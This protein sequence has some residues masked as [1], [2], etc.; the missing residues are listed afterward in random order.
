[1]SQ[2]NDRQKEIT[3]GRKKERKENEKDIILYSVALFW[4]SGFW[5]TGLWPCLLGQTWANLIR[6]S[7]LTTII[8]KVYYTGGVKRD[9]NIFSWSGITAVPG[10]RRFSGTLCNNFFDFRVALQTQMIFSIP[11]AQPTFFKL[12]RIQITENCYNTSPKGRWLL[13]PTALGEIRKIMSWCSRKPKFARY[14]GERG[15]TRARR[16]SCNIR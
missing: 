1:M 10:A 16:N 11:Q 2:E 12:L 4:A 3:K 6:T 8:A 15:R 14:R 7:P 9:V 13:Q 5:A